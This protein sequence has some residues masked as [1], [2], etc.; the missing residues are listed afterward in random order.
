MSGFSR[1]V[2]PAQLV[3]NNAGPLKGKNTLLF[4]DSAFSFKALWE[5]EHSLK[6]STC[7]SV[8]NF[9]S[10]SLLFSHQCIK[11]DE[12]KFFPSSSL[13]LKG[14]IQWFF[15][16]IFCGLL[17]KFSYEKNKQKQTLVLPFQ[18]LKFVR[19][20]GGQ[21]TTRLSVLLVNINDICKHSVPLVPSSSK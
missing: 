13:L 7:V 8:S 1:G 2:P 4:P 14:L 19:G 12:C 20:V 11:N 16:Y 18:E 15:Q 6:T 9:K 10:Q 17:F 21:K 5:K 3:G